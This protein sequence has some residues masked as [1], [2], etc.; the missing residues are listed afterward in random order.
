MVGRGC[1][2]VWCRGRDRC[3]PVS[4]RFPG[5]LRL[6]GRLGAEAHVL[7]GRD[8]ADPVIPDLCPRARTSPRS[9]SAKRWSPSVE[10]IFFGAVVD[11][12]LK[13][14]AAT[15]TFTSFEGEPEETPPAARF[16]DRPAVPMGA[17]YVG[18]A[19]IVDLAL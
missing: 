8:I 15:S 9:S 12:L 18:T 1:G 16:A 6:A 13:R 7:I 10:A 5:H 2:A 3:R 19:L 11:A 4:R 17:N 14:P